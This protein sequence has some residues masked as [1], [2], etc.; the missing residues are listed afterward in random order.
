MKYRI[1]GKNLE[2]SEELKN[3]IT[4]KFKKLEKF[5]SEDTEAVIT[6]K[7]QRNRHILE[8]TIVQNGITFRAE[9]QTNDMYMS[10]DRVVD[11]IERQ[12]RKNKT[13]LSRKIHENAFKFAD[14]DDSSSFVVEEDEYRIMRTK[15]VPVKPITVDEAI[16]QMNLLSHEF[17]VFVNAET[18]QVNVVYKRKDDNYGLIE[19]DI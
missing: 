9:E 18:Q 5:F 2:V 14:P 8:L 11:I 6:M 17:F 4:K 10:I 7:I 13:R 15:R 19:P 12:I 16:L 3:R 1:I